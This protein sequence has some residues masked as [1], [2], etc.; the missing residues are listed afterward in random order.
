MENPHEFSIQAPLGYDSSF[1]FSNSSETNGEKVDVKGIGE[2][3][4]WKGPEKCQNH[5]S[6]LKS[7]T[8]D[9]KI[10]MLTLEKEEA[11]LLV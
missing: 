10:Q 8:C 7:E 3:G 9:Q 1:Y 2:V 4:G 11:A 6:L 5:L